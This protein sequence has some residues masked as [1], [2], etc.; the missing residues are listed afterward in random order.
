MSN[1]PDLAI[2]ALR[3]ECRG[4]RLVIRLT[5]LIEAIIEVDDW[6][7]RVDGDPAAPEP[8]MFARFRAFA[9]GLPRG[10]PPA[11]LAFRLSGT[12]GPVPAVISRSRFGG[13][14][15]RGIRWL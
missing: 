5:G 13:L 12:N 6:R 15:D 14:G 2:Q 11:T 1:N 8:E 3:L 7:V 9:R 4:S 10:T